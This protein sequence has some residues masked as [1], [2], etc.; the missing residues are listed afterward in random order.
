PEYFLVAEGRDQHH[1]QLHTLQ[2]G[3][4][5][6]LITAFRDEEIF[7]RA[8]EAG[9]ADVMTKPLDLPRL[10]SLASGLAARV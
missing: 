8:R 7:R 5:V 6:V 2:P 4:P 9:A 3:L 10:V 1:R